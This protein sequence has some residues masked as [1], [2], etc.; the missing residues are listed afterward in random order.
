[1]NVRGRDLLSVVQEAQAAIHKE[2]VLPP[3][4]RLEWGG[5]FHH[6]LEARARLLVVVPLALTLIL[7]LL[8][9]AFRSMRAAL[10]IFLNVPFAIA[11]GVFALW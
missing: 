10:L 5:Q 1:F 3:S 8:W 7:F 2:V 4:Y 9:L 6:F 11:G